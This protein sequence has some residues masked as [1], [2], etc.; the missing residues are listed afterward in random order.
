VTLFEDFCRFAT[1]QVKT[2]D[3]DPVYPVLRHVYEQRGYSLNQRVWY[4]FLYTAVYSLHSAS[5]LWELFEEPC[6]VWILASVPTGV[7]RRG[8]RGRGGLLAAHISAFYELTGGNPAVWLDRA[9]EGGWR[10]L[11]NEFERVPYAGKW[12]SYKF[13][14]LAKNVLSCAIEPPDI[15]MGG[16]GDSAGPIAGLVRLT[17]ESAVRCR[18]DVALQREWY[19]K[20]VASGVPFT[21]LDQFETAL[22]DFNSLAKGAY[23][24][25][26]DIDL[27]QTACEGLP[28]VFW[29]ARAATL[30]TAHL[31][32]QN[33]WNGVRKSL[34]AVYRDTGVVL[35]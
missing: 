11:Q 28:E 19:D 5:D 20:S 25:G 10:A 26:H 30:D 2:G 15:G 29:M 6:E 33:G 23:Y 4:T 13:A 21:G 22:C 14:D 8:F 17:G 3:I 35:P 16:G 24:V 27:L 9:A 34:K 31:G 18:S 32:E 7:E 12:A 1:L